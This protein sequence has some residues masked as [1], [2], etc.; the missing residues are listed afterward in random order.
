MINAPADVCATPEC[1]A[2]RG[3]P[4]SSPCDEDSP[5]DT[6]EDRDGDEVS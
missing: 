4:R 2:G 3:G 6:K 5:C 1:M